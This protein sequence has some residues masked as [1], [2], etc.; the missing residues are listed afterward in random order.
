M[1]YAGEDPLG[2][3]IIRP[4]MSMARAAAATPGRSAPWA[5]VS[6]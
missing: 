6:I 4:R 2:G 1:L 3:L 5:S